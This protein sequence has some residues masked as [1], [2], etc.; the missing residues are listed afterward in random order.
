MDQEIPL[1]L[2][3]MNREQR[4]KK[5][6]KPNPN[7]PDEEYD[8]EIP[9]KKRYV[10]LWLCWCRRRGKNGKRRSVSPDPFGHL[11]K[12]VPFNQPVEAPP[13]LPAPSRTVKSSLPSNLSAARKDLLESERLDVIARYRQRMGKSWRDDR[14]R[15]V[16]RKTVRY[17]F[18]SQVNSGLYPWTNALSLWEDGWYPISK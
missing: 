18:H 2:G 8:E 13:S 15:Q 16:K 5:K 14:T 10:Y 1:K 4:P 7:P 11:A 17:G 12:D 3:G 9:K 6:K